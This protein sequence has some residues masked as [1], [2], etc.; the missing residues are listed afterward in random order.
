MYSTR[1]RAGFTYG[2]LKSEFR[3]GSLPFKPYLSMRFVGDT[4]KLLTQA[5]VVN[6]ALSERAVIPAAGISGR[7]GPVTLWGEAG[8]TMPFSNGP[9]RA[10]YRGG[11]SYAKSFGHPLPGK[12]WF[13]TTNADSVF[14]SRFDRDTL[15][16]SQNRFGYSLGHIQLGW[17]SNLTVDARRFWWGNFAELGPHV[18]VQIAPKLTLSADALRGRHLVTSGIPFK[19]TYYDLRVS[20]WY[21]ATY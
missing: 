10:D 1:W 12:G 7:L 13:V 19:P 18:K 11:A 16:Y 20:I 2:Q 17:N 8:I 9:H 14:V 21:A 15:V 3:L 4:G 6:G 5:S